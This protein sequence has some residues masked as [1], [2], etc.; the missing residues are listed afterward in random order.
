MNRRG[1]T[2]IALATVVSVTGVLTALSLALATPPEVPMRAS[3]NGVTRRVPPLRGFSLVELMVALAIFAILTALVLGGL[4]DLRKQGSRQ[5]FAS[6]LYTTMSL[7]RSRATA[8]QAAQ[9]IVVWAAPNS[10][11]SFGYY[12]LEDVTSP[13][14]LFSDSQLATI[15]ASLDPQNPGAL[16]GSIKLKLIDSTMVS[17][18]PFLA[19]ASGFG[20][21]PLPFPWTNIVG[22]GGPT[23]V[24]GCSFCDASRNIGAVAFLPNSR[25]VFSDKN[26]SYGWVS[27]M[28]GNGAS[29]RL[30]ALAVSAGGF[31]QWVVQ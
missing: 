7:A 11:G 5:A 27:V 31:V 30:T 8:R 19:S 25:A 12:Y 13:P 1:F 6:G 24:N 4:S 14:A 18:S 20:G 15:L 17:S 3:D 29:K 26:K 21:N 16:A 22:A 23:T 9:V 2:P 10:F 28:E